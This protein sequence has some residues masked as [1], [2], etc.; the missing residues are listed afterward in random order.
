MHLG[1][2]QLKIPFNR[3]CRTGKEFDYISKA[4]LSPKLS[5]DGPFS[6]LCEEW[7]ETQYGC[8]KAFLTPSCTS[9]LEMA[10][11]LI[12]IQPGDEVIMPSY[13]FVSTANAFALRGARIVFVDIR[14]DTMNMDEALVET[15]ITN[16]TKAIV[17][18]HYAGVACEMDRIMEIAEHHNCYVIEDAAQAMMS[19]YRGKKVGT[20]GQLSTLSFHETKNCTSG[21]EGGA[22]IINDPRFV[23]QAE[24]IREKGTNRSVFFRGQVD[25]YTWID[26]GSSYLLSELQAA[27]LWAQLEKE[28]DIRIDRL[29]SWHQYYNTLMPLAKNGRLELP[30]FPDYC[31]H[32]GHMFYL[33]CRDIEVRARLMVHL[34][35]NDVFAVFHYVPLHSSSAGKRFSRFHG[36]DRFTT[37]ESERLLRLPMYYGLGSK[38]RKKVIDTL[39]CFDWG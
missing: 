28:H 39:L 36:I 22:L 8:A 7:L 29:N 15:A 20:H 23:E 14:P 5:G 2:F 18:V 21:G 6:R 10:A 25:K 35:K 19:S 16:K 11:I 33:K 37:T 32:N 27:Y 9:A 13:T 38:T 24:I 26:I 31:R 34:R 4:I 17:P 12:D 30:G 1:T 3:P